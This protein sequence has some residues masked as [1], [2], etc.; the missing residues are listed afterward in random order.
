MKK[1]QKT[2]KANLYLIGDIIILINILNYTVIKYKNT[3]KTF[4][5]LLLIAFLLYFIQVFF[6]CTTLKNNYKK[7]YAKSED[8]EKIFEIKEN[9][10]K[11]NIDGIKINNEI[12]KICDGTHIILN[13]DGKIINTSISGKII[14]LLFGGKLKELPDEGWRELWEK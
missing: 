1:P 12:F 13:K 5:A 11:Y 8:D 10:K 4:F 3:E 9:A 2:I 6:G 14:N 7:I